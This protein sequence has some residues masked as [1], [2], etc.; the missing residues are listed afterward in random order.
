MKDQDQDRKKRLEN[1]RLQ[2][3][4]MYGDDIFFSKMDGNGF[5]N[6]DNVFSSGVFALDMALRIGGYPKGRIVEIYGAE[7]SGKSTLAFYAAASCQ[8]SGGFVLYVDMENAID[9]EYVKM[10]G[11]DMSDDKLDIVCPACAEDVFDII[12]KYVSNQLA[13]CII[14]DSVAALVPKPEAEGSA[15]EM[16]M[17]LQA[18]LM[19]QALRKLVGMIHK[20]Q[21][22]VIFINQLRSKIGI[23]FGT[24]DVTSGGRALG[25]YS[26][27]RLE[28]KKGQT[29]KGLD[30]NEPIGQEI[31][32]AIK[33]SKI[34][35]P[36]VGCSCNLMYGIGI[37]EAP[38]IAE[39]AVQH[40]IIQK[41]GSWYSYKD[42]KIGQGLEN[43][44]KYLDDHEEVKKEIRD[45][46]CQK[47]LHKNNAVECGKEEK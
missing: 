17:G 14:V 38:M 40:E 34:A 20:S 9:P 30:N 10:L 21:C 28:T 41:S 27:V 18:R 19:S 36:G 35:N 6:P 12:E 2:I 32:I 45:L 25:Y 39:I 8:R 31:K 16:Q 23:V 33:K 29:I 43:A 24:P 15:G 11:L 44:S 37:P 47:I 46:I 26:S 1:N 22:T 13:D 4:K 3:K 42:Q 7:S 5:T